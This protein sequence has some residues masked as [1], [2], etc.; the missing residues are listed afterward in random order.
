MLKHGT[1]YPMA[2]NVFVEH[3]LVFHL[4]SELRW[5][6]GLARPLLIIIV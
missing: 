5:G 4:V 2:S 1:V 6:W 3:A